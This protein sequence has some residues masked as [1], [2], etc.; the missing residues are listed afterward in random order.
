MKFRDGVVRCLSVLALFLSSQIAANTANAEAKLFRLQQSRLPEANAHRSLRASYGIS[1]DSAALERGRFAVRVPSHGTMNARIGSISTRVIN[2]MTVHLISGDLITRVTGRK[3]GTFVISRAIDRDNQIGLAGDLF[4]DLSTTLSLRYSKMSNE[5]EVQDQDSRLVPAADVSALEPSR[6]SSAQR[7]M[8]ENMHGASDSMRRAV[9]ADVSA[10]ATSTIDVLAAYT[11]QA[12]S[13]AGGDAGV[14]ALITSWASTVNT[15]Y[16]NSGTGAQIQLVGIV[17]NIGSEVVDF[18]V[19]LDRFTNPGDGYFDSIHSA[20]ESYRADLATLFIKTTGADDGSGYLTC[21]LA[22]LGAKSELMTGSLSQYKALGFSAVTVNRYCGAETWSH[23]LGHNFGCNHDP[24][25][26]GSVDS[27]S[28]DYS[29]GYRFNGTDGVQ[30]RTIMAYEPGESSGYFSN[31]GITYKGRAVGSASAYNTQVIANTAPII[32]EYYSGTGT[33]ISP[34]TDGGG[35]S[36]GGGGGV[37]SGSEVDYLGLTGSV[38]RSGARV[39]AKLSIEAY[40]GEE[41]VTGA[42]VVI[43]YAAKR[44]KTETT[45]AGP[46]LTVDG[47]VK[48]SIKSLKRGVYRACVDGGTVCSNYLKYSRSR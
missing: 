26:A 31:P 16:V 20:R 6:R 11:T 8:A 10:N 17:A 27:S 24:A 38:R 48:F 3:R 35:D 4:L 47:G 12:A 1:L 13:A 9:A 34:P 25:N 23:E 28:Y 36:G 37:G 42:S 40:L 19:N 43:N 44:G 46:K 39:S 41:P 14:T 45:V 22:W 18:G 2:G 21:G 5:I 32:S 7:A 33:G 29:F 15:Q 30:Y